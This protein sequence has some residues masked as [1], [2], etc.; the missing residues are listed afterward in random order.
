VPAQEAYAWAVVGWLLV[1]LL[2]HAAGE[3][4]AASLFS[5]L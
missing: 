4:T 2:D 5:H 1:D 3:G